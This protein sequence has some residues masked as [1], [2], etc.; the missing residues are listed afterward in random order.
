MFGGDSKTALYQS[1]KAVRG[2]I[3]VC[4]PQFGPGSLVQHGFARTSLWSVGAAVID[5][6]G[7]VSVTLVLQHS[8]STLKMWNHKFKVSLK[9]T[10]Q[11]D[12]SLLQV[13]AVENLNESSAQ[14]PQFQFTAALHT[15]FAIADVTKTT[16]SPLNGLDYQD[17]V[18]AAP[19]HQEA[20]ELNFVGEVDRVYYNAP[21]KTDITVDGKANFTLER[22]GFLDLVTWNIGEQKQKGISDLSSWQDYV[23]AEAAAVKTPIVLGPGEKWSASQTLRAHL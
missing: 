17:K 4:W 16:F 5:E 1:D 8:E 21:E 9:T 23:C 10:L 7:S 11:S 14:Q 12:G 3:P 15:Y 19:A 6:A 20:A 13:L 2:G 18:L 22:K